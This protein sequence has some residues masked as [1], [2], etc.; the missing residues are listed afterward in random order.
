MQDSFTTLRHGTRN[1]KNGAFQGHRK[2]NQSLAWHKS[3]LNYP[4]LLPPPMLARPERGNLFLD[5][6]VG[7][8]TIHFLISLS[9]LS[10]NMKNR[11]INHKKAVRKKR[12]NFKTLFASFVGESNLAFTL[13]GW[14]H[15]GK[16]AR[17]E[18]WRGWNR[19][20]KW[21]MI[22]IWKWIYRWISCH[23]LYFPV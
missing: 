1:K 5:Y 11:S 15:K 23:F 2:G 4:L 13:D 9:W 14:F 10:E 20:Q 3:R 22:L 18:I 8:I 12:A 21:P 16:N 7:P 6:K 19:L 17:I